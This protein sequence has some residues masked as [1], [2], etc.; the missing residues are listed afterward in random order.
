MPNRDDRN[1]LGVLDL[2]E[3]DIA[4][5]TER[6]DQLPKKR[7]A[8]G[9]AAREGRCS[10]SGD[11]SLNRIE[12]LL[13]EIKIAATF[14]CHLPFDDKVEQALEIEYCISSEACPKRHLRLLTICLRAAVSLR[15]RSARTTSAST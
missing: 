1:V 4:R 8:A 14:A 5:T 7:T 11:A 13:R 2:E 12:G 6:D 15:C 10:Q 3:C 9:L